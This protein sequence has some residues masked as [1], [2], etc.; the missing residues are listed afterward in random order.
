MIHAVF[1][2]SLMGVGIIASG[3]LLLSDWLRRLLPQG[4]IRR[5]HDVVVGAYG[6]VTD[7]VAAAG[8]RL[9]EPWFIR[10][11]LRRRR[12]YLL[13]ALTSGLLGTGSVRAGLAFYNDPRGLFFTSPWV[14]GIGY[15][16]GAAAGLLALSCVGITVWYHHPSRVLRHLVEETPL[17]RYLLPSGTDRIAALSNVEER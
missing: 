3:A 12:T 6:A 2:P 15:G 8:Y 14:I 1:F 4:R 16:V 5:Q 13:L 11:G 9:V 7:A 10:R 17:G